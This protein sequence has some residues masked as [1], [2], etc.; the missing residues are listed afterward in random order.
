MEKISAEVWAWPASD[1]GMQG[2]L[3]DP[4]TPTAGPSESRASSEVTCFTL[5]NE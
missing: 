4:L 3:T 1:R 5:I 2:V